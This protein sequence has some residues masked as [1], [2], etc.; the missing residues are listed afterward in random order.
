M[1]EFGIVSLLLTLS[2]RGRISSPKLHIISFFLAVLIG[3]GDEFVQWLHPLRVG[4][5]R[6]VY[7]N[8]LSVFLA[9]FLLLSFEEK[10]KE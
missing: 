10:E 5:M 9:Q 6:D 1:I 3:L 7:I 4:N 2:F 8:I